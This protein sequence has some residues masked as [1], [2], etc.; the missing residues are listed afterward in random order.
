MIDRVIHP[1]IHHLIKEF[2]VRHI[3][4]IMPKMHE[5]SLAVNT[6]AIGLIDI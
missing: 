1:E 3:H 2:L 4:L 6:D 5:A